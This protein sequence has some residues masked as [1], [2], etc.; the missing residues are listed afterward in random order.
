MITFKFF[1]D[2]ASPR[3]GVSTLQTR[4]LPSSPVLAQEGNSTDTDTDT[5]A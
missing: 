3:A 4:A 5:N 1:T 2:S